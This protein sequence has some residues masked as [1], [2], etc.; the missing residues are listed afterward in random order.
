MSSENRFGFEWN[1]Y[2]FLDE[3]YKLQFERW[4]FPFTK[5]DFQGKKVLDAGCGMGRNS[6]YALGWGVSSI[7][8]FDYD[9]RSVEAAKR[10]LADFKNA[11]VF[12]KS[13]YD[14][15]WNSEFDIAISIG[16]I[17][18]LKDPKLALQ[19]LVGSLK[20]GGKLLIWVYSREGNEI[21]VKF[22]NPIR[23]LITSK[24]PVKT[25]Y[26]LSY[27]FSVPLYIFLKIFRPKNRYL[28]QLKNFKFWHM[29][30]IVFDQLIPEI[31][32]YWTKKQVEELMEGLCFKEFN[33]SRPPNGQ[34]WTGIGIK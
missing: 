17:H 21:V 5:N 34:G 30:S 15:N 6:F 12:Y 18:H 25:A 29:H 4:V 22:I 33:V 9:M 28:N 23:K 13:I 11:E 14:I 3:N 20:S 32:N 26:F 1:K 24:A 31:A 2:N 19:N 7:I 27:F 10:N 8:A 16:V